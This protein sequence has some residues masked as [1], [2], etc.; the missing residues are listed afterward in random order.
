ME[1]LCSKLL[2]CQIPRNVSPDLYLNILMFLFSL[3]VF[4]SLDQ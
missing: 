3:L 2:M 1:K 4:P